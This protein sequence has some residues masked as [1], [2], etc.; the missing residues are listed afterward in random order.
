MG[1]NLFNER[2]GDARK[3]AWH[4]LG[5]VFEKKISAK[6]AYKKLGEYSVR[7]EAATAGG[8]DLKRQAIL[9]DP[10]ADDPEVRVFGVVGNEYHL[11]TPQDV[12]DI[13]DEHIAKPIETIGALGKGETFF[14]STYLPTLDVKGDEIE[15][16]LLISNPMTGLASAEIRVTP[17]RVVCQNTLIASESMASQQL[18]VAHDKYVKQRM[19]DWLRE[20]YEFAEMTAHVLRDLFEEMTKVRVRDA[21]ARALFDAAYPTPGKPKHTAVMAV[22]EQ[23]I[24]WWEENVNLMQRR[25]DGAKMLFEGMGTGMDTKAAK[26]TLWG[27]YNAVVECEDY[28]KST[29]ADSVAQSVMFGERAAAKK[30]AFTYAV[31]QVKS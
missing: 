19:A 25:R 2:F 10:T 17:V 21:E 1:H 15:N 4:H 5:Q 27:A 22:M 12:C 8:I 20:T 6:A 31:A 11:I 16:Y 23:R 29:K 7:L 18:R 14:L 30:R 24:T 26:G 3:P 13:Y 28:R 9:R